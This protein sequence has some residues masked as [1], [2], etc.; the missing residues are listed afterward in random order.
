[1][2]TLIQERLQLVEELLRITSQ[3]LGVEKHLILKCK[4]EEYT[5]ARYIIVR[6]LSRY[7]TDKEIA[8]MTGITRTGVNNIRNKF[9]AKIEK[10]SLQ[11]RL[12]RLYEL[13]QSLFDM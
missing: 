5:D 3:Y 11:Q 12:A 2:D 9:S 13:T 8:A 4:A 6:I 10:R 1:M 7:Y